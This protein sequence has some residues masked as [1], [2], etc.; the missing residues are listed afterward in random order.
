MTFQEAG[1][2]EQ[3]YCSFLV[4]ISYLPNI[5]RDIGVSWSAH[6]SAQSLLRDQTAGSG[7]AVTFR[8]L[9]GNEPGQLDVRTHDCVIMRRAG[10]VGA[11]RS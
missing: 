11:W 8:A 1:A 2:N 9:H 5:G 10:L 4:S 6:Y 3:I 7:S